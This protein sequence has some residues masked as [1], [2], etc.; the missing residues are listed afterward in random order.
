MKS[1]PSW[2]PLCSRLPL[3]GQRNE[4]LTKGRHLGP[5]VHVQHRV[6]EAVLFA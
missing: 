4:Q 1:G 2:R 5:L 6:I 3:R